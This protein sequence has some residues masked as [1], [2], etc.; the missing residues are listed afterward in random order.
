MFCSFV[1]PTIGRVSLERAMSSVLFQEF[2]E[3]DTEIII[4]NDS[5]LELLIG[6]WQKSDWVTIINTNKRE[7]NLPETAAQQLPEDD[8]FGF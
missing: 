4:V 6:N 2:E 1:I 8:I 7:R 3:E 5:G